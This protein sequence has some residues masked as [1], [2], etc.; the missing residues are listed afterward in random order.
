MLTKKISPRPA[1]PLYHA[2][3]ILLILHVG[4]LY[5][6]T[7]A[8]VDTARV[9][10]SPAALDSLTALNGDD[11]GGL[12]AVLVVRRNIVADKARIVS[13]EIRSVL[14]GDA[15]T[16]EIE[17]KLPVDSVKLFVRHS[18]TL[19]DTLGVFTSP[20]FRAVWDCSKVPD[21]D[22]LHLQFGYI[23]YSGDSLVVTSP[24][25]PHRYVLDRGRKPSKKV[26]EVKQL[27]IMGA[28]NIRAGWT[29]REDDEG[30][31]APASFEID[32]DWS[33]WEG[34]EG[35][36]IG[37]IAHFRMLWTGARLFFIIRVKDSSITPL[38]FVGLHLDMNR[39]RGRFQDINHR[40]LR[41]NPISRSRSYTV[42]LT[43]DGF[44]HAD[45][46][47]MA[48][49]E[50]I[51]WNAAFDPDGRGYTIEVS[52]PFVVLADIVYA[53]GRFGF[54]VTVMNVDRVSKN[55]NGIDTII[56]TSSFYSWAGS[57]RFDRY[58]PRHWGTARV[59]QTAAWL[60]NLFFIVIGLS[61]LAFLAFMAQMMVAERRKDGLDFEL[62]RK[63]GLAEAVVECIENGLPDT[64]F[65]LE[66]VLK[67]VGARE[68]EVVSAIQKSHD[69]TFDRLL[70]F[71]RL[72]H[73]QKLMRDS[74][75]DIEKIAGLCGFVSVDA[76]RKSYKA[77]M[78]VDPDVSRTAA[79]DKIR[80][81]AEE[82]RRDD[83]DD[84]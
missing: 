29:V 83:E 45:S 65:C 14:S 33:K 73:S 51:R 13:P 81:D 30:V 58:N 15:V 3:L 60:K 19:A 27:D 28:F 25:L 12:P 54:D 35:Q 44:V 78:N 9:A 20:P 8:A 43:S 61:V 75:L 84:D 57:G 62:P 32:G 70:E 82:K 53:P 79:L 24:P 16:Y 47:N 74:S 34:V 64:K 48:V 77:L 40:N 26:Y 31:A 52:L 6:D 17:P 72:K 4:S 55:I 18:Q 46:V 68:D 11:G 67:S 80:E 63:G 37:D 71:K 10:D 5:A 49:S 22:Q 39:E 56:E 38:D 23:L 41:F 50:E 21:Q 7:A 1:G 59:V 69:S 36:D 66:D 76:Y 2:A 42:E